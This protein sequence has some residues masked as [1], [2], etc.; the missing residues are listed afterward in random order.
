VALALRVDGLD[1]YGVR[2]ISP[3]S[4]EFDTLAR[5][6]MGER[7]AHIGLQLR[8]ML[9]IVQNDSPHT[10]V[11]LSVVWDVKHASGMTTGFWGH[12][13]FPEQICGDTLVSHDAHAIP[14]G[15]CHLEANGL[16]LHGY[17]HGDPYFD[18]F[19]PQFVDQKTTLLKHAVEL[20]IALN[21]VIFA[22]GTLAG[23]DDES[24]LADLFSACLRAKQEWYRGIITALDAGES[25][26]Q[27]FRPVREFL[28]EQKARIRSG[29]VASD[30]FDRYGHLRHQSAA[31]AARWRRRFKDEEVAA[32]LTSAI[33]LE[34]FVIRRLTA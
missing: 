28:D 4:P 33:R 6:L 27:A 12:T 18:Q 2:L 20:H 15:S 23:A 26:E 11:S 24:Q 32:L 34:P 5:P 17:G 9:A 22:D 8:P 25:I 14:S 21:A 19:L 16:V 7:I 10:I 13:S 3:V 29:D 30:V 31:E 1:A